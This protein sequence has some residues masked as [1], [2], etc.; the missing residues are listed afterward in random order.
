VGVDIR[1]E[2]DKARA[3]VAGH[4]MAYP[5]IFDPAGRA[6][7]GFSQVPPNTT[8]ATLV[9]DRQGRIAAVFRKALVREELSPVV[10]KV[11][12]EER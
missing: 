7:L 1:D 9:V 11:A 6:A 3:F 4:A 2:R 8:P 10:D 12:A 5:S